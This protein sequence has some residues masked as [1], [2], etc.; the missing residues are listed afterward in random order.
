MIL[1]QLAQYFFH[2]GP[3]PLKYS[4]Y[5]FLRKYQLSLSSKD[6]DSL[7]IKAQETT[8]VNDYRT[9]INSDCHEKTD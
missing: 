2:N 5:R 7:G 3:L 8:L 6:L 4:T 9:I 1:I